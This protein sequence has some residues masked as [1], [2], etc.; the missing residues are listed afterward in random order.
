MEDCT[1]TCP[2]CWE[3]LTLSVSP[4]QV[5]QT[6]IEDC[7]VCCRPMEITSFETSDGIEL[8]AVET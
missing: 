6:W 2:Y 3:D 4:D 7:Q 1:V 5:G 8:T